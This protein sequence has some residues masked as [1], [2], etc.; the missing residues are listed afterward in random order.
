MKYLLAT[1]A[2]AAILGFAGTADAVPIIQFAQISGANTVTATANAGD[3]ATALSGSNVAVGITQNLGGFIGN[4][5]LNLSATSTDAAVAAGTGA[6]QHYNGTFEI[7]SGLGGT[8]TNYLSGTFTDAALGVGSALVLAIGAPPDVLALTSSV[9]PAS[10]LVNPDA[11]SFGLTN[12]LPPIAIA[13]T[14]IAS[15]SAT[16]AGNVS[17]SAAAVPE[18]ASLAILGTSILGLGLLRRHRRR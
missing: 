10:E 15:F 17:S 3:T 2:T 11:A 5:V 8:G 7:T 6:L 16:V 14:T 9:I 12:V 13:G 18:P 1:A 4:A